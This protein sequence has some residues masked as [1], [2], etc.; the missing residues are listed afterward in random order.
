MVNP[1]L[2]IPAADYEGHMGSPEVAQLSFLA[3]TF[4]D[5]LE[6]HDCDTVA[7]LGCATGNGLDHVKKEVTQRVTAVDINSEYLEILSRRYKNRVSGLEIVNSDLEK[8]RLEEKAYSLIFAGLVFEYLEPRILL[9][10]AAG[11][12]RTAGIMVAVLQLPSTQ[13]S[14]VTETR[15]TSLEL[16]NTIMKLVDPEQFNIIAENAGL[17][18][19]EEEKTILR[20]G[21]SFYIGIY[22]NK[23][24]FRHGSNLR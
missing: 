3:E 2:H 9:H 19:I 13:F 12:L 11:W 18:V 7:L 17:V 1:W 16:L 21:K 4:R 5:A 6:N 15:Y 24:A 10:K 22:R 14:K 23:N 20:T 8:C